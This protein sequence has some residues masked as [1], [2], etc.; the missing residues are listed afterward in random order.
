[1]L[2]EENFLVVL[3]VLF[4]QTLVIIWV[5]GRVDAWAEGEDYGDKLTPKEYPEVT[6]HVP[7]TP[8]T[9]P[10]GEVWVR[11]KYKGGVFKVTGLTHIVVITGRSGYGYRDLLNQAEISLDGRKTWQVA[12]ILKREIIWV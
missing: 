3:A 12:G 6:T 7:Y 1:M 8:E 4:A 5:A 2:T 9:F 10:F 11:H